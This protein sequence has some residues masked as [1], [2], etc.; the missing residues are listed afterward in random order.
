MEQQERIRLL[1][2]LQEHPERYTNEQI[3]QMLAD[4]PQLAEL[5]E[6]LAMTKRAFAKQEADKEDLPID[7]LWKQFASEHEEELN[8]L[9]PQQE[10]EPINHPILGLSFG[11]ILGMELKDRRLLGFFQYRQDLH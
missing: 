2:S 3:I 6:E 1:L 10:K 11:K 4:D 7:D 8:A 9:E 5:M